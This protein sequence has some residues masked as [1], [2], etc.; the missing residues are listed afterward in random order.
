MRPD[1]DEIEQRQREAH[2]YDDQI[3][4]NKRNHLE[5]HFR[6]PTPVCR[7]CVYIL[8]SSRKGCLPMMM[9]NPFLNKKPRRQIP[10]LRLTPARSIPV[11]PAKSI[12]YIF[13]DDL[14]KDSVALNASQLELCELP[15]PRF[16]FGM[17]SFI[18]TKRRQG[19]R[20]GRKRKKRRAADDEDGMDGAAAAGNP[21]NWETVEVGSRFSM[22]DMTGFMSL[23][24]VDGAEF[25]T[26]VTHSTAREAPKEVASGAQE[27]TSASGETVES[28]AATKKKKKRK[29]KKG[30]PSTTVTTAST[31]A[32]TT[33]TPNIA[34]DSVNSK[35]KPTKKPK[36]Q[37]ETSTTT[38]TT[39]SKP[40]SAA[41]SPKPSPTEASDVKAA[42][43][44]ETAAPISN[45]ARKR[46]EKQVCVP[47]DLEVATN[48]HSISPTLLTHIFIT[49]GQKRQISLSSQA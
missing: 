11:D 36:K 44:A 1:K 34:A 43:T 18:Q 21:L 25:E 45:R 6:R 35:T 3:E 37:H 38:T 39:T 14:N 7:R 33:S 12:V 41:A 26:R 20:M 27:V 19:A 40:A 17:L 32:S 9:G 5:K 30:D 49:P 48:G 13:K 2:G 4:E 46:M 8:K 29:R 24:E 16:M 28:G 22:A 42:E 15:V 10:E 47:D 23:E 31:T